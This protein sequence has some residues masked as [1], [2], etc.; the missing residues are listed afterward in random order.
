MKKIKNILL[1]LL[2]FILPMV[3]FADGDSN[4][5]T[6]PDLTSPG[7]EIKYDIKV[8]SGVTIKKYQADL[9]YE[10]SVLELT[11]I[12]NKG[13]WKGANKLTGNSP[14]ELS[15]DHDS[16]V[17]G[18]STIATLTFKVKKDATKTESRISIVGK[19]TQ[20]S[21]E[22]IKN[23]EEFAKNIKIRSTDNTLK[24][25]KINN[26]SVVNFSPNT[27]TYA[28]QVESNITSAEVK[29]TLSN[30]TASFVD[31]FGPRTVPLEYG[32]N[33][34][35]IKVKSA[36]G[37][38]KTYVVTVTRNDNRGSNNDLKSLI[39]NAGE[40]KVN[41]NKDTLEYRIKTYKLTKLDV[42]AEPYD[43]KATVEIKIKGKEKDKEYKPIIGD[44]EIEIIVTSEDGKPKTYKVVL[45]NQDKD[46]D[47]TLR[48]IQIIY[49]GEYLTLNPKFK[50]DVLDYELVYNKNYQDNL[51]IIPEVNSK[52][53]DVKYDEALLEST[54]KD[55][56]IG[57]K[58]E[59]RV[60]APDGTEKFYTITFVKDN[61]INFF[62]ILFGV[63]LIILLIVFI[64]L[65][66]NRRKGK[67]NNEYDEKVKV[68][69]KE[70]E[71]EL[72]KTKRLN[73]INLE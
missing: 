15:F 38:E 59:I 52:G 17:T 27:D 31:K 6:G 23:L 2:V 61:R 65:L 41:F 11:G 43:N 5:L 34:I 12:E 64:K 8:N 33:K 16:G 13:A 24:D 10:T 51:S 49:K 35:E 26:Q 54:L 48:S 69:T 67:D 44:N 60:F 25:I 3:V 39:I 30:S 37:D 21:D 70:D 50:S 18:E 9:S 72:V 20:A 4:T 62:T 42:V 14:L 36:S 57:G 19:Y 68:Y 29:A 7:A 53:D 47:V 1:S 40:V 28:M 45:D 71:K 66:I 63:I 32:E 73:K 56:K 46:L 22:T 55:I 58:V